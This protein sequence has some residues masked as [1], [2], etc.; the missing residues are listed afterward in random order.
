MVKR[1]RHKI[2]SPHYLVHIYEYY[3]IL[4]EKFTISFHF[5]SDCKLLL[6]I[7]VICT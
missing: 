2:I 3:E 6:D 4:L 7:M 1:N 5:Y